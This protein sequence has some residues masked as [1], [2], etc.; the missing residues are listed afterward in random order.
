MMRR[1]PN[2]AVK[3]RMVVDTAPDIAGMMSEQK[4]TVDFE[5]FADAVA[6]IPV[7]EPTMV[8]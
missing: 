4:E 7:D 6:G 3:C 8:Q 1:Y 2:N 5:N